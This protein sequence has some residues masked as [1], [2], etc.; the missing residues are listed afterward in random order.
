MIILMTACFAQKKI[1]SSNVNITFSIVYL[2][3][4]V[5]HAVFSLL[6]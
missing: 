2:N 6:A 5:N 4:D 1:K 3:R